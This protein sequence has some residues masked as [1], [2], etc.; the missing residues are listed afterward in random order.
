VGQR[1][2]PDTSNSTMSTMTTTQRG[3]AAVS[4]APTQNQNTAP[5][6]EFE[7]LFTHDL[8]K[9]QK[10]WHDG[11]LRF[12]TFNRRLMVYDDSKNFIGDLHYRHAD[13]LQEGEELKLDKGV[14][15]DVGRRTGQ[16]DTDLR[17]VLDRARHGD[18]GTQARQATPV[19]T[20]QTLQRLPSAN[21]QGR[22]KSLAAVL[23]TSQGPIGRARIALKSSYEQLHTGRPESA[24]EQPPAKRQKVAS[25]KENPLILSKVVRTETQDESRPRL[26]EPPARPR[27]PLATRKEVNCL[28]TVIELSS[29]D[30]STKSPTFSSA[31]S[32]IRSRRKGTKAVRNPPA[33]L[34]L[35]PMAPRP[36]QNLPSMPVTFVDPAKGPLKAQP[37]QKAPARPVSHVDNARTSSKD[38]GKQRPSAHP[39]ETSRTSTDAPGKQKA[40]TLPVP[41]ARSARLSSGP[42]STLRFA[43]QKARPK[44]IYKDLLPSS[45]IARRPGSSKSTDAVSSLSEISTEREQNAAS[46]VS[47][48]GGLPATDLFELSSLESVPTQQQR[49]CTPAQS[50]LKP[51]PISSAH[52]ASSPFVSESPVNAMPAPDQRRTESPAV[53]S[54]IRTRMQSPKSVEGTSIDDEPLQISPATVEEPSPAP[55]IPPVSKLTLMDQRLMMPPPRTEQRPPPTRQSLLQMVDASSH[56]AQRPLD[57]PPKTPQPCPFRRVLSESDSPA[58]VNTRPILSPPGQIP[59]ALNGMQQRILVPSPTPQRRFKSPTKLQRAHSDA[60]AILQIEK[61]REIGKNVPPVVHEEEDS[62][63]GPWSEREAFLLFD[64]WPPGRAKPDHPDIDVEEEQERPMTGFMHPRNAESFGQYQGVIRDGIDI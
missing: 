3:T 27:I 59:S 14:L 43:A 47:R 46:S 7:C 40:S 42:H 6:Y 35:A 10:T 24:L 2:G 60:S 28:R 53:P 1:D 33:K 16:T 13:E 31:F 37:Q 36:R 54:P 9:K 63:A 4:I 23:G 22:P 49:A 8:R 39:A 21:T 5:V 57:V 30:E 12:H 32:T 61:Q 25:G 55:Q 19:A 62:D 48:P 56:I 11:S 41:P 26:S 18:V 50:P 64:W 20:R 51:A 38:Q 17:E 58:R 52:Q 34:D 44:L 29:E 15:V 45:F